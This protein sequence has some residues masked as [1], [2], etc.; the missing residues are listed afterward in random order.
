VTGG[1]AVA[2]PAYAGT[3]A[4]TGEDGRH[5]PKWAMG[6]HPDASDGSPPA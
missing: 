1:N 6:I 2:T 4:V 3:K 5:T